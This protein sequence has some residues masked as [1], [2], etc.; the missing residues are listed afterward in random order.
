MQVN[1]QPSL[2]QSG[3]RRPVN[4]HICVP[5]ASESAER[6]RLADKRLSAVRPTDT[7]IAMQSRLFFCSESSCRSGGGGSGD[8]F[9]HVAS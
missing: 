7:H 4:T 2:S 5:R 6:L 1:P 9:H 3:I 8:M